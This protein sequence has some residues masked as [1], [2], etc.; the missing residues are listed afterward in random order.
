M[1]SFSGN[2]YLIHISSEQLKQQ[3]FEHEF[4]KLRLLFRKYFSTPLGC[5]CFINDVL[6]KVIDTLS[7]NYDV[8]LLG[9]PAGLEHLP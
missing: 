2:T 6:K 7:Q 1:G 3:N 9:A 5:Y 8:T 4:L